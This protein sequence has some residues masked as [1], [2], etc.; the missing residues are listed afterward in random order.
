MISLLRTG[1]LSLTLAILLFL[2]PANSQAM[3]GVF[4]LWPLV[5]YRVSEIEGYTSLNI[6]GPII[7]IDRMG[8]ERELALRPLYSR[9]WLD[10]GDYVSS[11]FLYPVASKKKTSDQS[12]FQGL[13]LLNWDF[14]AHEEE[15]EEFQLFPFI[16]S[17]T[18]EE[19]GRYFAFFPIGGKIYNLF[20]R[21]EI[22]FTLFP[23]Y[24]VTQKKD[25]TIT[26]VL[27]PFFASIRGENER[28]IK[29]WP[30]YGSSRKKGVYDKKM[31]LWPIF[32]R[33]DLGL[34]T[35]NP[36]Q[37][38]TVFPFYLSDES[39]HYSSR[40]YL[41]PFFRH[42]EDRQK[43]YELWEFP[44]PIFRIARGSYR[45]ATT[46]L[47]FYANER[48]GNEKKRWY[49]WPL[50]KIEERQVEGYERRR[51][52]VLFFLYSNMEEKLYI[53]GAQPKKRVALWPLFT[54][55]RIDGVSRFYT[56]SLL[57]PILPEQ[58][59]I[60]RNWAP[61]WWI[62]QKQWKGP[63]LVESFLWNLYW[64]QK[65]GDDLAW[66]LFPLLSYSSQE[67]KGK[68]FRFIK[69]LLR[70]RSGPQGKTLNLLYLPWGIHW[71][72]PESEIAEDD[73]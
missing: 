44:W 33:Y 9:R 62:Y 1:A 18:D 5:D 43:D 23:L 30:L 64:R 51:S 71:D 2:S 40:I 56:L 70:Y 50:Y 68:D 14:P 57:E 73:S 53:Q 24:S 21:D 27:W 22:R 12:L 7:N 59:G 39:P 8:P 42:I 47:P 13:R 15:E 29:F 37:R 35:A 48:I 25:T 65:R 26:N 63:D 69:G 49:L 41:W 38:R 19:R 28:G 58:D 55:E 46:F 36:L 11:E 66:E 72:K 32:F 67:I 16:F 10:P 4:T 45:E 6:L 31:F 61:L 54:Y 52:R 20:G 3:E 17:G 60:R 34:D